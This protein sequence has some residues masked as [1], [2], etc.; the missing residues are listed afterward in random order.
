MISVAIVNHNTCGLLRTCLETIAQDPP[1]ETIVVDNAS[2][3][4]SAG[5]VRSA[6]PWVV[7]L[8][9]PENGGYGAA[10]NQAIA[11]ARGDYVLL[12][13]S[14]AYPLPGAARALQDHLDRH[15]RAGVVGPRLINPDGSLQP[16]CYP[17]PTG[18][19]LFLEESRLGSLARRVPF[20]QDRY[21]RAWPHDAVREIPWVL[22]AALAIRRS[23]FL[24]IGGFDESYFMYAEEIDLCFRLEA[25]GW[26]THFTPEATVV[27]LGGGSTSGQR[28]KMAVQYFTSLLRF[29]RS[30]YSQKSA[31]RIFWMM[32]PIVFVRLLRDVIRR[33]FAPDGDARQRLAADISAWRQ[34]L[35]YPA[36][37]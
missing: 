24:P 4:G 2:G 36:G 23:A 3:D 11:Q 22:G 10:A 17:F 13:N 6:F 18:F 5:M 8:S 31:D 20:L 33:R 21:L 1:C 27:H 28:A 34:I 25:A 7:L 32:K 37:D 29:H 26:Q 30:N 19:Y 16:S 35:L 14:D 15:P 9:N 12:L